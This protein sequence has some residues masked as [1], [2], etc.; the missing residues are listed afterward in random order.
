M[1]D[2]GPPTPRDIHYLTFRGVSSTTSSAGGKQITVMCGD[3]KPKITAGYANW[4]VVAR[5]LQT[6]VTTFQGYDPVSM[7][8]SLRFGVWKS[9]QSLFSKSYPGVA[10]FG[11]LGVEPIFHGY[12]WDVSPH[13]AD[14]VESNI[15]TLEWMAGAHQ[16]A[17]RPPFVYLNS[18]DHSGL[19]S[20]LIPHGYQS[21]GADF[22]ITHPTA[23]PWVI[24]G[25]IK[26]GTSWSIAHSTPAGQRVYQECTLTLRNYMGFS[27]PPAVQTQGSYVKS[28]VGRDTCLKIASSAATMDHSSLANAIKNDPKN[29]PIRGTHYELRRKSISSVIPRGYEVWVPQHTV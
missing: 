5:P 29:N 7:D 10:P 28:S 11:T 3:D 2:I 8:L 21:F 23:W 26:W 19:T 4:S 24:D 13:A 14:I 18:Y 17:G 9:A 22:G 27:A 12:G 1:S 25:G 6:G 20:D 16:L 15:Q